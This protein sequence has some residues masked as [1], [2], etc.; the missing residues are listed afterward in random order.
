MESIEIN[1]S[2]RSEQD[3]RRPAKI[4]TNPLNLKQAA[5]VTRVRKGAES[6]WR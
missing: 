4:S 3:N 6:Q 5:S 1:A 2:Q